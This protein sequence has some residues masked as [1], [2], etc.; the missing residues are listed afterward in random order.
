MIHITTQSGSKYVLDI[1]HRRW[2]RTFASSG[3]GDLRTHSGKYFSCTYALGQ[4]LEMHCPP[5][6]PGS[7]VSRLIVTT[8][9][10]AIEE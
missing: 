5:F 6:L 2:E 3:S 10:T 9:I 8:P 4:C 7:G 1:A